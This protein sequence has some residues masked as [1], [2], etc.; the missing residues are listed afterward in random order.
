MNNC[1]YINICSFIGSV[2]LGAENDIKSYLRHQLFTI[3][4]RPYNLLD[5]WSTVEPVDV[6]ADYC[7]YI[8]LID[9]RAE[10]FI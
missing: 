8:T 10:T 1:V 2:Y 7:G 5:Q 3:I 6:R 9:C 4:V